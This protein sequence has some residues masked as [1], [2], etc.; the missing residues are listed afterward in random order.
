MPKKYELKLYVT[1]MTSRSQAALKNLKEILVDAYKGG[2]DLKV[3]DV[4]K[5]PELAEDD[6]ILATPTLI[7]IS[8][9]PVV[10]IIGDFSV[11]EKVLLCL[12]LAAAR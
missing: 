10:K 6:G 2:Y 8:P 7:K 5:Q 9:P 4:M 11:K 3:I 12:D 1:G